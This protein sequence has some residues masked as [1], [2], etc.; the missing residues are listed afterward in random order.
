[1]LGLLTGGFVL[2]CY[3]LHCAP[4][5]SSP[6]LLSISSSKHRWLSCRRKQLTGSASWRWHTQQQHVAAAAQAGGHR[7]VLEAESALLV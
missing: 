1:M 5:G 6:K 4:A 7:L 3:V 2:T